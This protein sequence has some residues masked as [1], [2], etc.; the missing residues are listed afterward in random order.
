MTK[1]L[2]FFINFGAS[3]LALLLR[4]YVL[5]VLWAWF[6]ASQFP[7]AP[8]IGVVAALGLSLTISLFR[9]PG[10]T[11]QQFKEFGAESSNDGLS[12][13][14]WSTVYSVLITLSVWLM[15]YIFHC[16]M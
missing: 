10:L 16:Y 7:Q 15:G 12:F 14:C 2:L 13:A 3:I 8:K 6:I 1:V 5:M 4:G 9:L 11:R